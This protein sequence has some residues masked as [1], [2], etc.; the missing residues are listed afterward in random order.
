MNDLDNQE[1][2]RRFAAGGI[3]TR[4]LYPW[5]YRTYRAIGISTRPPV[6]YQWHDHLLYAGSGVAA[7]LMVGGGA[8]WWL[9]Q[10]A[11]RSLLPLAS[12]VLIVPAL[13]WLRYRN[14]RRRIGL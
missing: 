12:L 4:H 8:L 1:I 6:L 11:A 3:A 10:V 5:W 13:N 2:E 7:V 9:D 14:I